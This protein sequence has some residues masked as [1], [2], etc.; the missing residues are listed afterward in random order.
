MGTVATD[1]LYVE[2]VVSDIISMINP[3][4]Y[5]WARYI[6]YAWTILVVVIFII[7]LF[8]YT[9]NKRFTK[10]NPNPYKKETFAMPRGVFRGFLALSLLFIVLLL[11]LVTLKG[12]IITLGKDL[13]VPEDMYRQ[14][15]VAF[16]MVVAF[17][18][19]GKAIH[20]VTSA[21]RDKTRAIY[22]SEKVSDDSQTS[23]SDV[24]EAGS[25]G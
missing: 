19:G 23:Q 21:D 15:M 7:L 4:S 17:Y 18:F 10:D 14:L 24:D 22:K 6:I 9:L 11:E 12:R 13:Y 3:S 5:G 20:H 16:Q 25:V 2:P 8:R 1:T